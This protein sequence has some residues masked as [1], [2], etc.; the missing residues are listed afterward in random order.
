MKKKKKK[1]IKVEQ[2][3]IKLNLDTTGD[4]GTMKIEVN[5]QRLKKQQQKNWRNLIEI[6]YVLFVLFCFF[7]SLSSI[8][9][10]LY[11]IWYRTAYNYIGFNTDLYPHIHINSLSSKKRNTH[12]YTHRTHLPKI[13]I[14]FKKRIFFFYTWLLPVKIASSNFDFFVPIVPND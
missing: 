9:W 5:G 1:K 4:S 7:G 14:I 10:I 8:C 6:D 12:T 2:L 3:R 11:R 13:Y